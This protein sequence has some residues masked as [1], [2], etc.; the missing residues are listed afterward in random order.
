MS[1][2]TIRPPGMY[3]SLC[4]GYCSESK[5][6]SCVSRASVESCR[7]WGRHGLIAKLP[8]HARARC[9]SAHKSVDRLHRHVLSG[10]LVIPGKR[11]KHDFVAVEDH[12]ILLVEKAAA[13]GHDA[14]LLIAGGAH[15]LHHELLPEGVSGIGWVAIVGIAVRDLHLG[16]VRM[17]H[18]AGQE[19]EQGER[20]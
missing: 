2:P 20:Q 10:R 6:R 4:C 16:S 3:R 15:F 19:Q 12:P 8:E 13:E 1:M 7:D 17:R 5:C 11:E 14:L 18:R 9:E